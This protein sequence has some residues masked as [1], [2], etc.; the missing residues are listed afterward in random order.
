M[1]KNLSNLKAKISFPTLAHLFLFLPIIDFITSYFTWQNIN[2]WVGSVIKGLLFLGA[3]IYTLKNKKSKL[4]PLILIFYFLLI[5]IVSLTFNYS[6]IEWTTLLLK[7]FLLPV[8][9]MFFNI[10]ND[11]SINKTFLVKIF[12]IYLLLLIVP[13]IFGL[14]HNI[15]EIYPNKDAYLSF[16]YSGN[17]LS[18]TLLCLLPVVLSYILKHHNYFIKILFLALIIISFALLK[19]KTLILGFILSLIYLL[20]VNQKKLLKKKIIIF[21]TLIICCLMSVTLWKNFDVALKFYNINQ[22]NEVFSMDFVN[23]VLLSD[24]L[25]YL[26]NVNLEYQN[27]NLT[28]KLLG[29]GNLSKHNIKDVEIDIFDIFYSIGIVGIIVYLIIMFSSLRTMK[30]KGVYRFGFYL[31]LLISCLSGHVLTS[32]MASI[33]LATLS[34]A[35]KNIED[36]KNV[37]MVSNMFPSKKSKHYGAFVKNMAFQLEQLGCKVDLSYMTKHQNFIA[38]LGAYI[39]FYTKTFIKSTFNS[40]DFICVHYISHS[41]WPVMFAYSWSPK[42]KLILFAHGNDVVKDYAYEQKNIN[43]S[44]KYLKYADLVMCPS[45]YFQKIIN[46]EY[47][48]PLNKI[49]VYPSGGVDLTI[50]KEM[51]KK[52]AKE[53]LGLDIFTTYIGMVS[54]IEK[55]KGYDTLLEALY[56]L[57]EEKWFSKTKVIIIGSGE[58]QKRLK[59]LIMIYGLEDYIIQ[60]EFVYQK[61]LVT[62]YNAFDLLI[63]PTKRRSESLGL[64]GLEAMAVKTFVIGC[65]IYGPSEYL[66]DGYNSL[67]Y[68]DIKTGKELAK[69]INAYFKL[70]NK[71]EIINNAYETV[72]NFSAKNTQ[73]IL[74]KVFEVEK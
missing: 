65:D 2:I 13:K 21:P 66:K 49:I 73:K 40:Y 1:K 55:N 37:L 54:R 63:F 71:D 28:T 19:T 51:N 32:A 11:K 33:W 48:Y 46:K 35:N 62:Y 20:F 23:H 50:F 70:K 74:M 29:L 45:H 47:K 22:I 16:F 67:T 42:T 43:R 58:E 10:Y 64:V 38:K 44:K 60:K 68:Q 3:L 72:K 41:T 15:S 8:L 5:I 27:S 31:T 57:K 53:K 14:G 34:L 9:L 61:D 52:E 59:S 4:M 25:T 6:I 56:I 39:F 69:K 18:A 36:K 26:N 12:Y 24:R 30:L 7:I 17:E